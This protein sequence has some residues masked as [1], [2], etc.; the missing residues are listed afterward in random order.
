[1]KRRGQSEDWLTMIAVGLGSCEDDLG[2]SAE[3][4]L[5]AEDYLI[6]YSDY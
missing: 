1:M 2:F 3:M 5:R 6:V 4:R